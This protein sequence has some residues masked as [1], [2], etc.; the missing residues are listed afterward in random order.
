PAV[1]QATERAGNGTGTTY[2]LH[3]GSFNIRSVQNDLHLAP[4]ERPWRVRR[5]YVVRDILSQHVDVIGVQEASQNTKYAYLM[6]DG[7][8]QYT[9]LMKGLNEA[10]GDYALTNDEMYNCERR[11]TVYHCQYRYRGASRA[12]RILYSQ[13]TLT[14][15]SQG[16][17]EYRHQSGG[18]ND[19]RYLPWARFKIK[20]TG[21]RFFFASTHLATKS[22]S[23]Q[24]AQ[25][26]ELIAKVKDLHGRLPVVVTGDFQ[27]SKFNPPADTMMRAMRKAGFNDVLNQRYGTVH[28]PHRRAEKMINRWINTENRFHRDVRTFGYEQNHHWIGN[29]VDWIFATNRL[30]VKRWKVV[31]H[32]NPKTLRLRGV[33][34][35][36]HNMVSATIVI[37]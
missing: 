4:G 35:S 8:N 20:A 30:E 6:D 10:G 11:D 32:Y 3:V 7:P 22:V 37:P 29:N 34:P 36:D 23:L 16:S 26:R 1:G 12:T 13:D 5:A 27:A 14:L 31:V 9:D 18:K 19:Q 28:L 33:I 2:N 17:Y 15:L 21:K 24:R 25:W